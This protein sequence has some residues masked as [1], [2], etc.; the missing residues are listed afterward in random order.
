MNQRLVSIIE[1]REALEE[2]T[3][4]GDAPR[5]RRALQMLTSLLIDNEAYEEMADAAEAGVTAAEA[6][7]DDELLCRSLLLRGVDLIWR[8]NRDDAFDELDRCRNIARRVREHRVEIQSQLVYA[9]G[10]T[11]AG[12][13]DEAVSL[14]A[15]ALRLARRHHM[16]EFIPEIVL[17]KGKIAGLRGRYRQA[18]SLFEQASADAGATATNV[19]FEAR[20]TGSFGMIHLLT[21]DLGRA[22]QC[23]YRMAIAAEHAGSPRQI[24]RALSNISMVFRHA[25]DHKAAL[26]MATLAMDQARSI[27]DHAMEASFLSNLGNALN[28]VGRYE[29]ALKTFRECLQRARAIRERGLEIAAL[30][31]IGVVL[32]ALGKMTEAGKSYRE[33]LALAERIDDRLGIARCRVGL[34]ILMLKKKDIEAAIELLQAGLKLAVEVGAPSTVTEA[35][36][37]LA[38]CHE[39][40]GNATEALQHVR[41]ARETRDTV[42]GAERARELMEVRMR[43]AIEKEQRERVALRERNR[44]LEMEVEHQ[45]QELNT[46]AIRLNQTTGLLQSLQEQMA[47]NAIHSEAERRE[48][49]ERM[50]TAARIDQEW[51]QFDDR[52][53]QIHGGFLAD[54]ARRFPE[55]TPAELK[56]SALLRTQIGTKDIANLLNV[57]TRVVEKHRWNIRRKLGLS[58]GENLSAFLAK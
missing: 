30:D 45:L 32:S 58:A 11:D 22:L 35:H 41:K 23:F 24:A 26:E 1:A 25:G 46:M 5:V 51:K 31:N 21:G 57:G 8:G 29:E 54:L 16:P 15:G 40:L 20:L 39:R 50:R 10:L 34:G 28:A 53:E 44:A 9:G 43:N 6:L 36:E 55:L 47:S 42:L 56:V 33:S 12:A 18:M 27:D 49:A 37:H 17:R 48:I 7:H 14:L 52:F 2:A 3:R 13:Y 4:A 19:T 38:L